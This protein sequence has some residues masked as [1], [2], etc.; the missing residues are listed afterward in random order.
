VTK[1]SSTFLGSLQVRLGDKT[2][3][4]PFRLER[5]PQKP[6]R[7]SLKFGSLV[8]LMVALLI[9]T[10][11]C[12]PN[13]DTGKYSYMFT[14]G[15]NILVGLR[16]IIP[17]LKISDNPTDYLEVNV[18]VGSFHF[19]TTDPAFQCFVSLGIEALHIFTSKNPEYLGLFIAA[20]NDC[21]TGMTGPT[22]QLEAAFGAQGGLLPDQGDL[23]AMW[24][25]PQPDLQGCTT[26]SSGAT[27][28]TLTTPTPVPPV[29]LSV[30]GTGTTCPTDAN[31]NYTCTV[32]LT[33]VNSGSVD[34]SIS[35]ESDL[36]STTFDP[37]SGTLSSTGQTSQQVTITIPGAD[38]P[39]G[40][41]I[42]IS[43]TGS[44]PDVVPF[45][46]P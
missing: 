29:T 35:A 4:L 26:D 10:T 8:I 18:D 23:L 5:L 31:G 28:C 40:G 30:S 20:Y 44:N 33:L 11:S 15:S 17:P 37:S 38:C 22:S 7:R 12:K 25:F 2:S 34:W 13:P 24:A 16:A 14:V 46:C 9:F 45:T 19:S 39:A 3:Y 41:H 6:T 42:D 21:R 1:L 36:P 32:T 27:S 43:W